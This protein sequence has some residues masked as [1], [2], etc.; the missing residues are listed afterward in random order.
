[1]I[2]TEA[3]SQHLPAE[4]GLGEMMGVCL[5]LT[6]V[7]PEARAEMLQL[8]A[9]V[10]ALHPEVEPTGTPSLKQTSFSSASSAAT[11]VNF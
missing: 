8:R 2:P 10:S 9:C 1:M 3:R 11:P 4:S 5:H 6:P 7:L